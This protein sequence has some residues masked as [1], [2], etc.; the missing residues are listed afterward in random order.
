M[1]AARREHTPSVH[2]GELQVF[3][4]RRGG[5]DPAFVLDGKKI[6]KMKQEDVSTN[7]R[8]LLS[9]LS[10]RP[11]Y[12]PGPVTS[13]TNPLSYPISCDSLSALIQ[14]SSRQVSPPRRQTPR[15]F[16]STVTDNFHHPRRS[17]SPTPP[18]STLTFTLEVPHTVLPLAGAYGA[19]KSTFRAQEKTPES[20]QT[21]LFLSL[22]LFMASPDWK[23]KTTGYTFGDTSEKCPNS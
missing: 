8:E 20:L 23:T 2:A 17:P 21:L 19:Q 9:V 15:I 3:T 12:Y 14:P 10:A 4:S 13:L 6:N 22:S 11:T 7:H 18:V 5:G 1:E 16:I